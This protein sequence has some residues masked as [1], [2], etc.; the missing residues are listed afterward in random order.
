LISPQTALPQTVYLVLRGS[1]SKGKVRRGIKGVRGG[2][3]EGK[4]VDIAWPDL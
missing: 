2:E 4:G 1:T 3:V